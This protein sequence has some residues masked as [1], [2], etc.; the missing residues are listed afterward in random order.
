MEDDLDTPRAT[1]V[2][3]DTVRQANAA[4]DG[5]DVA[6]SGL[7]AAAREIAATVGLE[8][9]AASDVP[10]EVASLAAA[11]DAARAGKDFASADAIR[12][13]LQAD[14]WTVETGKQGTT[15]RR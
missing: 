9:K 15:V 14:G 7:V 1:A 13:Q 2:L 12:A 11:L 5:D 6:A 8:L 10:D 4:L 3:F